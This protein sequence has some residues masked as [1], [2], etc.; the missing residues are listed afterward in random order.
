MY[1][2]LF[3][4]DGLRD[5]CFSTSPRGD[6]LENNLSSHQPYI[7]VETCVCVLLN[8]HELCWRV[9]LIS[10]CTGIQ[11]YYNKYYNSV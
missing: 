6:A 11:L 3:G 1:D 9:I 5:E 2:I 10:S 4:W 7:T 8:K